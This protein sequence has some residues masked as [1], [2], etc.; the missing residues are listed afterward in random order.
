M[1]ST[2]CIYLSPSVQGRNQYVTNEGSEEYFMNRIADAAS[3]A[4]H[5]RGISSVRNSPYDTLD[6]IIARSNDS[7]CG[8]HLAIHSNTAPEK[9]S[10]L[11]R[12][13]EIYYYAFSSPGKKAAELFTSRLKAIYPR[14][15]LAAAVPNGNL[16]ELRKTKA[17]ALLVELGYHDSPK[18][19]H[20]IA[21]HIDEIGHCLALSSIDFMKI[22]TALSQK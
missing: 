6:R 7:G 19:A 20:W 8:F 15:E 11:L 1:R 21:S 12:G 14:P 22:V 5:S 4:L 13:P 10:G 17:P 2:P 9:L 16:A 3:R 18:D